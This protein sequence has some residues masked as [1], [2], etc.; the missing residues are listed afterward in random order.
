MAEMRCRARWTDH[1]CRAVGMG[2]HPGERQCGNAGVAPGSLDA[3]LVECIE[4]PVGKQPVAAAREERHSRP[5]REGFA[6]PVLPCQYAARQRREGRKAEISLGT[7]GTHLAIILRLQ[8]TEAV[9]H[10]FKSWKTQ[11][12]RTSERRAQL[13]CIAVAATDMPDPP[14]FDCGREA[15]E[16][17]LD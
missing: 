15:C 7:A 17:P 10:P 13:V 9:L 3:E 2:E 11:P 5:F 14:G 6:A 4:G 8:Q 16:R 1:R 12:V